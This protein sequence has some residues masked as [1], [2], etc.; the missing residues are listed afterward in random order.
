MRQSHARAQ[1]A[2]RAGAGLIL[3]LLP[4]EGPLAFGMSLSYQTDTCLGWAPIAYVTRRPSA[5]H[6]MPT[7]GP[8]APRHCIRG[9]TLISPSQPTCC[10]PYPAYSPPLPLPPCRAILLFVHIA[11]ISLL[12]LLSL[13]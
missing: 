13:Q 7:H 3:V 8:R 2:P 4:E 10:W 9:R 5:S 12:H 1:L 6:L 11:F